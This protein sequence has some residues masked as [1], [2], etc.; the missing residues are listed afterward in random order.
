MTGCEPS[1]SMAPGMFPGNPMLQRCYP[2]PPPNAM[3]PGGPMGYPAM[4]N[5]FM[6]QSFMPP[7]SMP[8]MMMTPH[9]PNG[10]P[11]VTPGCQTC[12]AY[13]M[14]QFMHTPDVMSLS[15]LAALSN[16]Q[17]AS[18]MNMTMANA[19]KNVCNYNGCGKSF[20]SE[21]DHLAHLKTHVS[22]SEQSKSSENTSRNQSPR[23]EKKSVSPKTAA[24]R[25]HPYMKDQ[26]SN[27]NNT[28]AATT[29][30]NN[31]A[32]AAQ[33]QAMLMTMGMMPPMPM[34]STAAAGMPFPGMPGASPFNPAA[35]QA[36]MAAQQ[37][38]ALH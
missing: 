23:T 16:A 17:A 32:M 1:T 15:F 2:Y 8:P 27:M 33:M 38:G 7:T 35:F 3:M 20:N 6:M 14:A 10:R 25:F 21:S 34:T 36:M 37:R 12:A 24:N 22:E 9:M 4:M 30:A 18:G 11:C 28:S 13:S 26:S 31:A 19:G 5:P 29:S